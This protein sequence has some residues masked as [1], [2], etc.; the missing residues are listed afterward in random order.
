MCDARLPHE[1]DRLPEGLGKR[2]VNIRV[3][4]PHGRTIREAHDRHSALVAGTEGAEAIEL[5]QPACALAAA[6]CAVAIPDGTEAVARDTTGMHIERGAGL[7]EHRCDGIP[8][9]MRHACCGAS[10]CDP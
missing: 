6:A 3:V 10:D 9:Q 5:A 4:A 8:P 1:R 2:A 7:T